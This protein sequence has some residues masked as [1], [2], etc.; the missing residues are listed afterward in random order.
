MVGHSL[1]AENRE[2]MTI[3]AV[4]DVPRFN[5]ENISLALEE[6]GLEID[7]TNLQIVNL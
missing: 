3:S 2:T 4:K 5:E 7:G 6:G 1:I